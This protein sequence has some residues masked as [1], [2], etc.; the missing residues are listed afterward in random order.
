MLLVGELNG[1]TIA[2]LSHSPVVYQRPFTPTTT[3]VKLINDIAYNINEHLLTRPEFIDK[4][5]AN[6]TNINM[7][8]GGGGVH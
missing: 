6:F 4:T 5:S 8:I 3:A 1:K 2:Y 7:I